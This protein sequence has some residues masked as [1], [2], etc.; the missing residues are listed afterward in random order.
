[1]W[2]ACK[3]RMKDNRAQVEKLQE[4]TKKK[5]IHDGIHRDYCAE[6]RKTIASRAIRELTEQ[7]MAERRGPIH[8]ITI[9]PVFKPLSVS[10]K[11]RVVSNSDLVNAISGL[12][13]NDCMCSRPDAPQ[14]LLAVLLHCRMVDVAL[15]TDIVKAYHIIRMRDDKLHLRQFLYQEAVGNPSRVYSHTRETFGFTPSG[16]LLEVVKRRAAA[17]RVMIDKDASRQILEKSYVDNIIL[18]GMAKDVARMK[19]EVMASGEYWGTLTRILVPCGMKRKFLAVSVNNDQAAA[20]ALGGKSLGL[21]YNLGEDIITFT[22]EV[23]HFKRQRGVKVHKELTRADLAA[24]KDGTRSF[25]RTAVLSLLQGWYNPL[26]LV[27]LALLKGNM[28]LRRLHVPELK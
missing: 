9:F 25:I 10:T 5:I 2:K 4:S 7:K 13:L 6:V 17:F 20:E 23:H 12:S 11:V 15:V 3:E 1:M 8:Y 24:L 14:E 22:M 27:G 18:G 19:G 16:M 28:M 26:G 21:S